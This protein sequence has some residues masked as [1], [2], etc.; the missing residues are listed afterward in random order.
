M[1]DNEGALQSA[2]LHAKHNSPINK[3]NY[4]GPLRWDQENRKWINNS[5]YNR[6]EHPR[7]ALESTTNFQR[8]SQQNLAI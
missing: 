4:S 8:Q 1:N 5:N 2:L 6:L 7:L 3:M